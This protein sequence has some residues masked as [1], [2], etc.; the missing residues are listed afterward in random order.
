MLS[1]QQLSLGNKLVLGG[2]IGCILLA[3]PCF[4]FGVLGL[5][6]VLADV[7]SAENRAMGMQLLQMAAIPAGVGG[8]LMAVFFIQ[9][10]MKASK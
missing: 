6:G 7:G 8:V 2:A 10:R 4:G 5:L 1:D 3:S 9:R